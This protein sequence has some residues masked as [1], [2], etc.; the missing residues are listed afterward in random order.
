MEISRLLLALRESS[1]CL[2]IGVVGV[3][4]ALVGLAAALFVTACGL[5]V[6]LFC[7]P[8]ALLQARRRRRN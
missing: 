1:R 5:V 4:L 6:R 8:V 3:L 2:V 7:L